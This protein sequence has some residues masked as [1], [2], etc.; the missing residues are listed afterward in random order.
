MTVPESAHERDLN[1]MIAM[2][3][4]RLES[5]H[6]EA[7]EQAGHIGDLK[8]ELAEVRE[9][10]DLAVAHDR[11]PYPT[12]WAHEQALKALETQRA[13]AEAAEAVVEQFRQRHQRRV[14]RHGSGCISCGRLWPCPD[15]LDAD[16]LLTPKVPGGAS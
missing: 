6:I 9:E 15:Y 1:E 16:A 11:Q 3:N 2:L 4:A 5:R 14:E 12:A 7:T 13:R 8:R 10:R